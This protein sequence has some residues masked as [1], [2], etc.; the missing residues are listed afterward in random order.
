VRKLFLLLAAV[1]L[2]CSAS[3]AQSSEAVAPASAAE[4]DNFLA[5]LSGHVASRIDFDTAVNV[6]D[7]LFGNEPSGLW[8]KGLKALGL[9]RKSIPE[10][11]AD[12]LT[13]E[14]VSKVFAALKEAL[15]KEQFELIK[16]DLLNCPRCRGLAAK[17]A[18]SLGIASANGLVSEQPAQAPAAENEAPQTKSASADNTPGDGFFTHFCGHFASAAVR[19]KGADITDW[20]D[21]LKAAGEFILKRAPA[22]FSGDLGLM[23][24][25]E[26]LWEI[27]PKE[28]FKQ[29]MRELLACPRCRGVAYDFTVGIGEAAWEKMKAGGSWVGD[30]ATSFKDWIWSDSQPEAPAAEVPASRPAQSG[31]Q[32]PGFW[33]SAWDSVSG[34]G[35][36]AWE[37]TKKGG[38]WFSD[39][40]TSAWNSVTD[41]SGTAWNKTKEGGSWL[42]NK[43]SSAWESLVNSAVSGWRR[44]FN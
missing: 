30:Q 42:G 9:G 27:L 16:H 33:A 44:L 3:L 34:W 20:W 37:K 2:L 22:V 24:M 8:E 28:Y 11:L 39:K 38:S 19:N 43:A 41:W 21:K 36:I 4:E 6:V 7:K 40:A 32:K 23:V 15:P 29:L 35:G 12:G 5:H 10:L 25:L 13:A 31:D 26:G 18:A 17:Y 1:A 14:N